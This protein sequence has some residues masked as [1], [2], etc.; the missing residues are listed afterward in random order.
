MTQRQRGWIVLPSSLLLVAGVFIGRNTTSIVFPMLACF[1]SFLAILLLKGKGRFTACLA[2]TFALGV[3]SGCVAFHPSLPPEGMYAVR[4]V[5]SDEITTG[6]FGQHRVYL[7]D[8]VLDGHVFSGGAYWTFYSDSTDPELSAGKSVSFRASLYHPTGAVNPEGYNFRE[9]LLQRG[10]HIGLYGNESLVISEPDSFSVSGWIAS[11]RHRLSAALVRTLGEETGAYASALILGMRSMIPSEDRQSFSRLGIAHILSVSGFHVGILIGLLAALFRLLRLRP[12]LRIILYT[13]ILLLYSA[14]CGM[15]QPVIRASLLLL[16]E[17]SGR[18]LNRPRSGFHLLAAA[19]F[20]MTLLSP[21]QVTSASYQLTFFAVFGLLLF[22]PLSDKV[23][24]WPVRPVLLRRFLASLVLLFGTQLGMLFP[25]LYFFQRLP[26]LV[27]LV[28][29]PATFIFS[30][31]II[32]LWLFMLFLPFP[33]LA[34]L[35]GTPLRLLTGSLLSGIRTLGS[36]PGLTVWIRSP[37]F[38]TALGILLL[39]G[40]F[41]CYYRLKRRIRVTFLLTGAVLVVLSLL[42]PVSHTVTEYIQ[43]SA[44]NADAAVLWDHDQVYVIDAG[45]SDSTLSTY[46]RS[47]RLTPDAVIL[48]HLH[49]DHAGGLQSLL[50]DEI[51]IEKLYLPYGADMLDIHPDF[52]DLL[53]KLRTSG[54]EIICLSRG[55][56]LPLPSGTLTVLWPETGKVRPGQDANHYSLVSCLNLHGSLF[57]HTGD[58]TGTYESYCASPADL[59]K[60][61][62]HGS[63]TSTLPDFLTAVSPQA[64]LLSCRHQSRLDAFRSRCGS[65]PVYG[66][67][68]T[69]A[70]TI[71]FDDNSFSVIPFLNNV[72]SGGE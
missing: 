25:V 60:A 14:L 8:V 40:G 15:N 26:L 9:Y 56:V 19:L 32:I 3:A 42:L 49:A 6:S 58:I 59:L 28:S 13:L 62:H 5:I 33:G 54:T 50:D 10:V 70:L 30:L 1:F 44:G 17:L 57:L 65:I 36:L 45:E 22:K 43:F 66:T 61:S 35:L 68:E 18:A 41:C 69:G 47:H 53:S 55:D 48:T 31:L 34:S 2:F 29:I 64:I 46:L 24:T 63:A 39:F 27:C 4:G 7:S 12:W 52:L 71:R 51:P 37:G 11:L 67:P 23:M 20:I 21:V 16:M 38:L 72:V